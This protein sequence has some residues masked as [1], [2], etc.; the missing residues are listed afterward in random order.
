MSELREVFEIVTKH[1][2]PDL[3]SW[4]DQER[5]QRRAARNRKLGAF[6]LAAALVLGVAVIALLQDPVD[7]GEAPATQVPASPPLGAQVIGLDGTVYQQIP[8]LPADAIGF[9]PSPDGNTIAFFTYHENEYRVASIRTD[10]TDLRYLTDHPDNDN[11]GDGWF[12]VSWSPDGTRLAYSASGDIYV[13]G[14]DGSNVQRIT[15]SRQGDYHPSWSPDGSTIVYWHGS[16][17]G[18]DG[19]PPDSEIFAIPVSGGTPTRLTQNDVSNIEP[20][21][22][23]DGELIAY[24]NDGQIWVMRADGSEPRR[25]FEG[26]GGGWAP[27]WSPDGTRI[28]FLTYQGDRGYIPLDDHTTVTHAVPLLEVRILDVATGTVTEVPV[29]VAMDVNGVSWLSNDTLL[30]NRYD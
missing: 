22:S 11:T 16:N 21:W 25:M 5:W 8:G 13:M 6:T 17:S 3:D 1:T 7:K 20:A 18:I 9:R 14:A 28:A 15:T 4:K 10:G 12:A 29:R 27:S 24:W 23:P 19:G 30:V 2:E 26:E